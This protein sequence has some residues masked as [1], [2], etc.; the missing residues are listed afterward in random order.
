MGEVLKEPI[1]LG[2]CPIIV[3]T[4]ADAERAADWVMEAVRRKLREAA[5]D[6]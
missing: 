6:D 5:R 2:D 4:E 1:L 3:R